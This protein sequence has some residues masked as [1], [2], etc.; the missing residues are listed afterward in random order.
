[1]K[2]RN[3]FG[4]LALSLLMLVPAMALSFLPT[5]FTDSYAH[6]HEKSINYM[7]E[8]GIFT[9]NPDGSFRPD[10]KINRAELAKV[11][12]EATFNGSF[13]RFR[14]KCFID[15]P[16]SAWYTPYVCFMKDQGIIKG[17]ANNTYAP[18]QSVTNAEALKIIMGA[19]KIPKTVSASGMPWYFAFIEDASRANLLPLDLRRVSDPMTRGQVADMIART[20]HFKQ[21]NMNAFLGPLAS[22]HHTYRAMSQ[23]RDMYSFARNL[24]RGMPIYQTCRYKGM[25][26]KHGSSFKNNTN[27][28]CYCNAGEVAFCDVNNFGP[29]SGA[30]IPSAPVISTYSVYGSGYN[31]KRIRVYFNRSTDKD[32]YVKAYYIKAGGAYEKVPNN[33]YYHDLYVDKYFRQNVY[34]YAID[35]DGNES[36]KSSKY[37]DV[38]SS[39]PPI[40]F[41]LN[42][43]T[44]N[45]AQHS[46]Y[47]NVTVNFGSVPN[48]IRNN[49]RD[50]KLYVDG[51]RK[52]ISMY[53][54]SY[55]LTSLYYNRNY[56]V[57]VRFEMNNGAT[58]S[59]TINVSEY[60]SIN[61]Y[62][63]AIHYSY[64]SESTSSYRVRVSWVDRPNYRYKLIDEGRNNVLT[65]TTAGNADIALSYGRNYR[66]RLEVYDGNNLVGRSS[67]TISPYKSHRVVERLTLNSS[68]TNLGANNYTVNFNWNAIREAVHYELKDLNTNTSYY[69]GQARSRSLNLRYNTSYRY[70]VKAYN[71][72]NVLLSTSNTI[73]HQSSQPLAE[74]RSLRYQANHSDPW[75]SA[76]RLRWT[77]VT[78]AAYYDVDYPNF[79]GAY[80]VYNASY[81][82]PPFS[83][84]RRYTVRAYTAENSL[85]ASA[86]IR[87]SSRNESDY[88]PRN[89]RRTSVTPG[90]NN[91]YSATFEFLKARFEEVTN[92]NLQYNL[93]VDGVLKA[94]GFTPTKGGLMIHD[95][96]YGRT[97]RVCV[98][99]YPVGDR[100]RLGESCIN[101]NE[102][103]LLP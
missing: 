87:V 30:Y 78:N 36:K 26:Y 76:G 72:N 8:R 47:Y 96:Q 88:Q 11:V 5:P 13:D 100:T 49:I 92:V 6:K 39:Q 95:F 24:K 7:A 65:S 46:N 41:N 48:A 9:G 101:M 66:I 45:K 63:P 43:N 14:R 16:Y 83:G 77:R 17:Y 2:I 67:N 79:S 62:N 84:T 58:Y 10:Y 37:V 85:I 33:R 75:V 3:W 98:Q 103:L 15:V 25:N 21:G 42:L 55:R 99:A 81:D 4:T 23:G 61:E 89:L 57:R 70:Q 31:H 20:I 35:N 91:R 94:L 56:S 28:N 19:Y 71:A 40:P 18:N 73:S 64:S 60:R 52:P 69:S 82:I 51:V 44:S 90:A 34:M 74:I 22:L 54:T 97:Y 32:G 29:P 102:N 27:Q 59:D 12:A 68:R 93:Y 1:M 53:A 50:I 80:R 86:D 38:R